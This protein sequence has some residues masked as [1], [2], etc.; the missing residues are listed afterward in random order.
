MNLNY[1]VGDLLPGLLHLYTST[2]PQ[3]VDHA[4][5]S[6]IGVAQALD[7]KEMQVSCLF[8]G[9]FYFLSGVT[10]FYR[11]KSVSK[12]QIYKIRYLF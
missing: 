6:A 1:L 4:V 7:Q 9:R 12:V 10:V 8:Y 5:N 2:N 3:I 11:E